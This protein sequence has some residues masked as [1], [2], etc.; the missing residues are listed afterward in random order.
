MTSYGSMHEHVTFLQYKTL[1]YKVKFL[2]EIKKTRP[3][4]SETSNYPLSH[5]VTLKNHGN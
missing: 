1:Q 5:G 4:Q 2:A 3:R